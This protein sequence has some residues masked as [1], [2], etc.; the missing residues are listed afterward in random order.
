MIEVNQPVIGSIESRDSDTSKHASRIAKALGVD[1]DWLLSGKVGSVASQTEVYS[2]RDA[3]LVDLH[4]YG[5]ETKP[6]MRF[7]QKI[8]DIVGVDAQHAVAIDINSDDMEPTIL[9][10][11]TVV[12]DTSKANI[13]IKNNRIYALVSDGEVRCKYI[14]RMVGG[15]IKLICKN[16]MYDDEIYSVE[17]FESLYKIIGWVFWWSTLAK[18]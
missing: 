10:G 3:D 11:S 4:F 2:V 8:L 7:S 13:P 16:P 12:V 9:D 5:D 18:W 14:Q 15:K 1:V 17:E 6:A